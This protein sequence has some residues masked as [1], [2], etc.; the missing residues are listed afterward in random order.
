MKHEH[1]HRPTWMKPARKAKSFDLSPFVIAI[2]TPFCMYMDG[3]G[4]TM[5]ANLSELAVRAAMILMTI[6]N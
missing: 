3:W 6:S 2:A 5:L 4:P 1:I